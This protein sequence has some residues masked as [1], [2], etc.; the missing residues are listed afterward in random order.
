MVSSGVD[1]FGVGPEDLGQYKVGR[2]GGGGALSPCLSRSEAR[3]VKVAHRY[4]ER[5]SEAESEEY[6]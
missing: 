3:F 5:S 6:R 4:Y 1:I 2:R